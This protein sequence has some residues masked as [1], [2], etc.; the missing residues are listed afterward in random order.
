MSQ[1]PSIIKQNILPLFIILVYLITIPTATF[2]QTNTS[3]KTII[4]VADIHNSSLSKAFYQNATKSSGD[5]IFSVNFSELKKTNCKLIV[6][7]IGVA[8]FSMQHPDT[9]KINHIV[10][11]LKNYRN[12]IEQ[13]FKDNFYIYNCMDSA[14]QSE[15]TAILFGM[16]G[17]HLLK[18]ELQWLDSLQQV[19]LSI[20]SP[21]HWFH[22]EFIIKDKNDTTNYQKAP[23]S[24]LKSTSILSEK[25]IQ[26]IE[27]MIEKG[28]IID[29]SH[30]PQKAFEQ[31]VKINNNRTPLIASHS[32]T[33]KYC[34]HTRNLTDQQ[35]KA[36]TK[37]G[38]IIGICLHKP[39]IKAG[40]DKVEPADIV[41]HILHLIKIGGEDCVA[42]G[43]DFEG[44]I[45]PPKDLNKIS[46]LYKIADELKKQG[47]EN[48]V[49]EKVMFRNALRFFSNIVEIRK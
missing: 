35:I 33:Y 28:M 15:K 40:T 30:M 34:E 41:E 11:F 14:L 37:T 29:L 36:I 39:Y 4:S 38:G 42:I 23:P 49:I 10:S 18:G 8:R 48:E 9:I 16:E 2:S 22:N 45:T 27:Q 26:L 12:Y 5:T 21:A 1:N 17:S 13:N 32:N 7:S 24:S 20:I 25:G 31:I 47:I 6:L 3:Q 43:T 19:G 44:R 46:D